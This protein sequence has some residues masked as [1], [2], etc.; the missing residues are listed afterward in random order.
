MVIKDFLANKYSPIVEVVDYHEKLFDIS[1][2]IHIGDYLNIRDIV[3]NFYKTFFL[4]DES[5]ENPL[6]KKLYNDIVSIFKYYDKLDF[7]KMLDDSYSQYSQTTPI[8]EDEYKK[9][10]L[11]FEKELRL[12]LIMVT[13]KKL[14][15]FDTLM[16]YRA[17][18][19]EKLVYFLISQKLKNTVTTKEVVEE[20]SHLHSSQIKFDFLPIEEN[21]KTEYALYEKHKLERMLDNCEIK[22]DQS[23]ENL[24]KLISNKQHISFLKDI[25]DK[26]IEYLVTNVEFKKYDIHNLIIKEG[27]VDERIYFLFSGECRVSVG[28]NNVGKIGEKQ[29]FGEFAALDKSPRSATIRANKTSVVMSFDIDYSLFDRI[30]CVFSYLYRNIT[31]ELINKIK[32]SNNKN[33]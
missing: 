12:K 33:F 18:H 2:D 21:I 26:Y 13:N 20:Y 22:K 30:P 9:E 4:L 31:N 28:T 19:S 10:F 15:I 29:I 32:L 14:F 24:K 11:K 7:D 1:H 3:F 27:D 23:F 25:E 8:K 6:D 5:F 17:N 16:W